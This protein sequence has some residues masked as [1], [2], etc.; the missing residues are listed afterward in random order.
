M[1]IKYTNKTCEFS[2]SQSMSWEWDFLP[3][4]NVFFPVLSFGVE[5]IWINQ[6]MRFSTLLTTIFSRNGSPGSKGPKRN[7]TKWVDDINYLNWLFKNNMRVQCGM[8]TSLDYDGHKMA[9]YSSRFC[10]TIPRTGEQNHLYF[11][12]FTRSSQGNKTIRLR[13]LRISV[14]A[15]D[16]CWKMFE[17][18][19]WPKCVR[20]IS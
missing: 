15:S 13:V 18:S 17:G 2:R 8:V 6:C 20:K 5:E 4:F 1:L 12:L 10:K 11:Y 14:L 19:L 3:I 16:S 9:P 7:P